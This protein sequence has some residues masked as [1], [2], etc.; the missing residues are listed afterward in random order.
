[1]VAGKLHQG[2][3]GF[4]QASRLS[5]LIL[6]QAQE[7]IED[8]V[9]SMQELSRNSITR[10]FN[11]NSVRLSQ[12]R[13][14][15]REILAMTY[16]A[17]D[18]DFWSSDTNNEYWRAQRDFLSGSGGTIQRIFLYKDRTPRLVEIML[19][20]AEAGIAVF[21]VPLS[22]I[23]EEGLSRDAHNL[24]V[25]DDTCCSKTQIYQSGYISPTTY[26]FDAVD[27]KRAKDKWQRVRMHA[28]P[29]NAQADDAPA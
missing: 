7:D 17:V 23:L 6:A 16:D 5:P 4:T 9:K 2:C 1:L 25:W 22:K 15:K 3:S 20:H 21:E 14:A 24:V 18:F 19:R 12:T 13:S 29:F 26:S 10:H 8:L 28:R 27:I 11:D